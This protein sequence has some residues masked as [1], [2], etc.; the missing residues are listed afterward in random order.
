MTSTSERR[1]VF[2][3]AAVLAAPTTRSLIL[4]GQ[5][6]QDARF[7]SR[8]SRKAEQ[9]ADSALERRADRRGERLGRTVPPVLVSMLRAAADWGTDVI[10]PEAPDVEA[11]LEDTDDG[12]R[13]ILASAAAAGSYLVVTANVADFGRADLGRLGISAVNPDLFLARVFTPAMYR[14]ALESMARRRTLAPDTPEAIQAS[15]TRAHPRL[16]EAMRQA[17]PD[18]VPALV[19]HHPPG[20]RFSEGVAA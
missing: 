9:E 7:T 17:Y 16:V 3:D 2:L 12:D 20:A 13:H 1:T 4:F 18:V 5:L 19:G 10:A 11:A 14:F 15:L 8:W 6:H